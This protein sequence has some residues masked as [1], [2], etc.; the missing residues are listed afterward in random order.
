MAATHPPNQSAT[1][2]SRLA[3]PLRLVAAPVEVITSAPPLRTAR[4]EL[5]PL[6]RADRESF[7]N[8]VRASRDPLDRFMPVHLQDESDDAMFERQLELARLGPGRDWLRFVC[9][10]GDGSIAGGV[11]LQS[12]SRGLEWRADIN[13]WIATPFAGRGLG[14][15]AF[16][17]VTEHALADLP[18]GL[19]LGELHA[20]I[21]RDNI[22][23]IAVARR[24]GYQRAGEERSYLLT[25]SR[26]WILHDLWIR[27][28]ADRG[29]TPA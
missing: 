4:L 23:S 27:R 1:G 7:L 25:D 11:N 5:R 3:S 28:H 20:W 22:Q 13:V 29:T 12:I 8:A 17:A 15:E 24:C 10:L 19:G 9:V 16:G 6:Q 2:P 21:T 18:H 26:S 14:S